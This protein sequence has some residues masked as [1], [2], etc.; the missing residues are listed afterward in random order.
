[1]FSRIQRVGLSILSGCVFCCL[2]V[3]Q[4]SGDE[5]ERQRKHGPGEAH[6]QPVNLPEVTPARMK[7]EQTVI[8]L[9][10]ACSELAIGG[11]GRFFVFHVPDKRQLVVFD[12]SRLGIVNALDLNSQDFCYTA[13]ADKLVVVYRDQHKIQRYQLPTLKEERSQTLPADLKV[14][15]ITM[16]AASNGPI[17]LG[18]EK[19]HDA[20]QFLDLETLGPSS[21]QL[22]SE[23]ELNQ[24]GQ[25]DVEASADGRVFGISLANESPSGMLRVAIQGR[26]V[27]TR[28]LKE[29]WG[30]VFL[31]HDGNRLFNLTGIYDQELK[32][33]DPFGNLIGGYPSR[34]SDFYLHPLGGRG[35][36]YSV[37]LPGEHKNLAVVPGPGPE[38]S[39]KLNRI[40]VPNGYRPD[41]KTPGYPRRIFIEQAQLMMYIMDTNNSLDVR[42]LDVVEEVKKKGK[43][44]LY[45]SRSPAEVAFRGELYESE[46]KVKSVWGDD[47][48]VELIQ[49]PDGITVTPEGKI[50]WEVPED[51]GV[52]L[53]HLADQIELKFLFKDPRG[54]GTV[55]ETTLKI[56]DQPVRSEPRRLTPAGE[57]GE[58][59]LRPPILPEISAS[60]FEGDR[61]VI[62]LPRHFSRVISGGGGRYLIFYLPDIRQ[63]ALF[64]VCRARV[65]N[66]LTVNSRLVSFAASAT[67][68]VVLN[69]DQ[70]IL[71]RY[72]LPTF[73]EEYTRRIPVEGVV[74]QL[75]MGAASNGPVYVGS[76]RTEERDHRVF[77][78]SFLDLESLEPIELEN[79]FP[80]G[81]QLGKIS[82][83]HINASAD[84][85]VFGF[86]M[87]GDRSWSGG[88]LEVDGK[89]LK[90]A[91]LNKTYGPVI[92]G[93][94]G[95]HLFVRGVVMDRGLTPVYQEL[96]YLYPSMDPNLLV[97][98][99]P[100]SKRDVKIY[101]L[102][103]TEPLVIIPDVW[104]TEHHINESM[105][106]SDGRYMKAFYI[107]QAETL[108]YLSETK[109]RIHLHRIKLD[110]ILKD[111]QEN[112]FF[113]QSQPVRTA[114]R[115]KQY[116]Y[117][118]EVKSNQTP[119]KYQ[120]DSGPAGMTVSDAGV[121]SWT[122]P[123][124]FENDQE[125]VIMTVTN[126]A[127]KSLYHPYL[128]S[129]TGKA[130]AR[131][132]S[133]PVPARMQ[134]VRFDSKT[135]RDRLD[136]AS[137]ITLPQLEPVQFA[138]K[139][140]Q[141]KLP[142][143]FTD[144]V[145]GG[146]GRYLILHFEKLNRLGVFD[147]SQAR[148]IKFV[149]VDSKKVMFAAGA[150]H[151]LV[152]DPESKILKRW[153]LKTFQQEASAT[154]P[155]EEPLD[156]IML[157][158]ASRGPLVLV[159]KSATPYRFFD[160]VLMQEIK[161]EHLKGELPPGVDRNSSAGMALRSQMTI[162]LENA[163]VYS[164]FLGTDR[165]SADGRMVVVSGGILKLTAVSLETFRPEGISSDLI[166]NP[167]GTRVYS[168]KGS[169]LS[170]VEPSRPSKYHTWRVPAAQS[171]YYLVTL[172]GRSKKTHRSIDM[173][174]L[175][176][177]GKE[178]PQFALEDVD[179]SL[180]SNKSKNPVPIKKRFTYLPD[181]NLLV[182]VPNSRDTLLLHKIDIREL[183]KESGE[184]YLYLTSLYPP[185]GQLR[186]LWKHQL[187]VQSREDVTYQLES[188]PEG[189]QISPD[190][191][192]TWKIPAN[193][194]TLHPEVEVLIKS[195][196]GKECTYT[197]KITIPEVY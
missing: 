59:H 164:Q 36:P 140:K 71:T 9:P 7:G 52:D 89:Q 69:H 159:V 72:E 6:L 41:V 102:G 28:F 45:V 114:A 92:P 40:V 167:A 81:M 134:L 143:E 146:G 160:P 130:P 138:G 139:Q 3:L 162:P 68:L 57:A 147:T 151:L 171:G 48:K 5:S 73:K 35:N 149:P 76:V 95:N 79:E 99:K 2:T 18:A 51:F 178:N 123:R 104:E 175:R 66:Y 64:D 121:V 118:L 101:M 63:L 39:P 84:G 23:W 91:S 62:K 173:L 110:Q 156:G 187:S 17:L 150:E 193:Y 83:M 74:V 128:L 60:A 179:F 116:E 56:R 172:P 131:S 142:G 168:T 148:I 112:Y 133:P 54:R 26:T 75:A 132:A 30:K 55:I 157:G 155:V 137:Q 37:S 103:D 67:K 107:P 117:A 124:D 14:A 90:T 181:A 1:M 80:S 111:R 163:R 98:R 192:L 58:T 19:T 65:V 77:Q 161:L 87:E 38:L 182:Q 93:P 136:R 170:A 196:S 31:N 145:T 10:G 119:L 42:S 100:G 53:S 190:G 27:Q 197:F 169:H 11:G 166:P 29:T 44:G 113:I 96:K 32:K 106:S 49:P 176:V 85:K 50:R 191:L 25:C 120:I 34:F 22:L 174:T 185:A 135:V 33:L 97:H 153:S 8:R 189:M 70:R 43:L 180:S 86:G 46:I 12:V 158:H 78:I 15:H 24:A 144:L 152:V 127:G 125:T 105:M 47:V 13:G 177:E 129:I 186:T 165:I 21:V 126:S 109:S 4:A 184:D 61:A 154:L 183:L 82:G 195:Q 194:S 141:V 108:V 88:T 20:W 94:D 115:G 16:G 188:A 122:V